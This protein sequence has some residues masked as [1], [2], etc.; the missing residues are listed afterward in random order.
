MPGIAPTYKVE[1]GADKVEPL[2]CFTGELD[3][4]FLQVSAGRLAGDLLEIP[5]ERSF[6][7]KPRLKSQGKECELAIPGQVNDLFEFLDPQEIDV[8]V[9]AL[10]F[11]TVDDLR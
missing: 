4:S 9:K 6:G 10:V 2:R 7:I 1:H 5:V 11:E 3:V 8:V